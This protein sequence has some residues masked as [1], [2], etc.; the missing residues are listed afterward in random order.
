MDPYR[1][2]RPTIILDPR[3]SVDMV[4]PVFF[5]IYRFCTDFDL[6]QTNICKESVQIK[7]IFLKSVQT[8]YRQKSGFC[9]V[10]AIYRKISVR[11]RNRIWTRF[12]SVRHMPTSG[13]ESYR[14]RVLSKLITVL[15]AKED[16]VFEVRT[17]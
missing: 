8:K 14:Y 13:S 17:L 15:L 3:P 4:L 10:Q 5:D 16:L 11:I 12:K 2:G 1:F 9:L 6:D 7:K